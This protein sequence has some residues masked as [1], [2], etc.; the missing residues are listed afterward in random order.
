MKHLYFVRHGL[1]KMN[2]AELWSGST[3]TPLTHEGR[4]QATSA[5]KQLAKD[6]IK[7][8]HIIASPLSRA[9]ETAKLIAAEI[10]Y[11]QDAIELNSLL[12]ERHF[13]VLEGQPWAIDM[14][15]DGITDIETSHEI[16]ERAKLAIA[17]L[18]SLPYDSILVVAHGSIGRAIRS[19]LL[20][21]HPYS[22]AGLRIDNAS[23]HKWR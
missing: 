23:I 16:L 17:H 7:I 20:A 13:G 6:K 1:T 15:L 21:D 11:A 14:D 8:N 3:E 5:G 18:E 9:H 4:K 2:Q 12:V 19:H 22:A 10:G